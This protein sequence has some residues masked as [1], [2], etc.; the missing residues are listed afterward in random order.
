MCNVCVDHFYADIWWE[1]IILL[2]YILVYTD[3]ALPLKSFKKTIGEYV[4]KKA[5]LCNWHNIRVAG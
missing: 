1:F 3:S 5:S 4:V 2:L